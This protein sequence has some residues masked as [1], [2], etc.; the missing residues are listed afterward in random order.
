MIWNI[1]NIPPQK[2]DIDEYPLLLKLLVGQGRFS[3]QNLKALENANLEIELEG[4]KPLQKCFIYAAIKFYLNHFYP[5]SQSEK[6][7]ELKIT[8]ITYDQVMK[9]PD[10]RLNID[11]PTVN[12]IFKKFIF[13]SILHQNWIFNGDD[14]NSWLLEN[15]DYNKS[16]YFNKSEKTFLS[17]VIFL[18]PELIDP[19]KKDFVDISAEVTEYAW[20]SI[21][22]A[23]DIY[24]ERLK[25]LIAF[26]KE[27]I[28]SAELLNEVT[29]AIK[30][31]KVPKFLLEDI[32]E[33]V[34][35]Q[36]VLLYYNITENSAILSE[37]GCKFPQEILN[38]IL[39]K[40]APKDTINI[41][42]YAN[43]ENSPCDDAESSQVLG[44]VDS[45]IGDN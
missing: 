2:Q 24:L 22:Q 14:S 35:K 45:N 10:I 42:Q 17:A 1:R 43:S 19:K 4:A 39:N 15:I 8:G 32:L 13:D 27:E 12:N 25:N 29:K 31:S 36:G 23:K 41:I 3:V 30:E 37:S 5:N 18:Q 40:T 9:A 11:T 44:A 16:G 38:L 26:S 21:K 20:Q 34:Q 7:E 28:N 6:F 33:K